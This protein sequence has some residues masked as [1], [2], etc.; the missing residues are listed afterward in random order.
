VKQPLWPAGYSSFLGCTAFGLPECL[1]T[2]I[3][4]SRRYFGVDD[5]RVDAEDDEDEAVKEEEDRDSLIEVAGGIYSWPDGV[6][7]EQEVKDHVKSTEQEHREVVC[8]A[9]A[10]VYHLIGMKDSIDSSSGF[11]MIVLSL[12]KLIDPVIRVI[13]EIIKPTRPNGPD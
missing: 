1:R 5:E 2:P 4:V 11:L 3:W 10:V 8:P 13:A 12:T 9:H 7:Q 6:N